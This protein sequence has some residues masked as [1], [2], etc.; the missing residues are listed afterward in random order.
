MSWKAL[1][2]F[3]HWSRSQRCAV[4]L[5]TWPELFTCVT[6]CRIW[7][8]PSPLTSR[9]P[10]VNR[11]W[12]EGAWARRSVSETSSALISDT[13]RDFRRCGDGGSS[14]HV[15][16]RYERKTFT[17]KWWKWISLARS[18]YFAISCSPWCCFKLSLPFNTKEENVT[19]F[20]EVLVSPHGMVKQ[21]FKSIEYY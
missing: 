13:W 9:D 19:L 11:S 5:Q 16:Y 3:E 12:R 15:L 14:L 20:C 10:E 4:M 21:M 6:R 2:V 17:Q 8:N 18:E 1:F 7:C